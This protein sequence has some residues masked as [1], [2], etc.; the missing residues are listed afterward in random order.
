MAHAVFDALGGAIVTSRHELQARLRGTPFHDFG[1]WL[2]EPL[3]FERYE[4]EPGAGLGR[5]GVRAA[6]REYLE[7]YLER[8]AASHARARPKWR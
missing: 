5:E 3:L 1:D 4:A 7:A 8:K 6:V 2:A